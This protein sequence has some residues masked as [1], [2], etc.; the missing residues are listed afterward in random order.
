MR[1][2]DENFNLEKVQNHMNSVGWGRF[3][4]KREKVEREDC[5]QARVA[6]P[7]AIKIKRKKLP[8]GV[9]KFPGLLFSPEAN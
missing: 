2:S 6:L 7:R 9:E 5:D 4:I 1:S 8:G 3:K